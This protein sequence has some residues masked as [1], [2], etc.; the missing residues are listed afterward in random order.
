M[1][2]DRG[3][4]LISWS[5]SFP[6]REWLGCTE[7][8]P[9]AAVPTAALRPA[10]PAWGPSPRPNPALTPAAAGSAQELLLLRVPDKLL[11]AAL[12]LG[13]PAGHGG[14][15]RL[16]RQT[17]SSGVPGGLSAGSRRAAVPEARVRDARA[18]RG[19]TGAGPAA[20]TATAVRATHALARG[21]RGLADPPLPL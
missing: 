10:P 19:G 17:R 11:P 15:R 13:F 21:A 8:D 4:D 1:W 14:G 2:P 3:T 7:R 5:L 9:T 12:L 20:P 16:Q 18:G 6:G